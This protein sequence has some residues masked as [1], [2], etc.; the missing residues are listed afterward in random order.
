ASGA[1]RASVRPGRALAGASGS[2]GHNLKNA[3]HSF[4]Q[5]ARI[6]KITD[7]LRGE[8]R[9]A[10]TRSMLRYA[11]RALTRAPSSSEGRSPSNTE[12]PAFVFACLFSCCGLR[13]HDPAALARLERR[14]YFDLVGGTSGN[15]DRMVPFQGT[16]V[17]RKNRKRCFV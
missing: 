4:I 9:V 11:L 10:F 6:L 2:R 13:G 1:K 3:I 14:A 8:A 12:E 15:G 16:R 5:S 17:R 7:R